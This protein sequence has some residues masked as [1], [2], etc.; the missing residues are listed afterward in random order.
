LLFSLVGLARR[1]LMIAVPAGLASI[2]AAV[3]AIRIIT[4]RADLDRV[5]GSDWPWKIPPPRRARMLPRRWNWRTP[6]A[7]EPR[8][9]R[10]VPFATISGTDR[11]LLC[12]IWQ[13]PEG[14]APSGLAFIYLFGSA[15]YILDKD[16][17]TR[18]LFRH[19]AAQGHVIM[20]V[21]YRLYPETDIPGMVGDASGLLSG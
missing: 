4:P 12:D 5:F 3:A 8:W 7:P 1:S 10:D 16:V 2:G 20:D 9:Q 13:P 17:G 11:T 6:R 14:V 19:L 18:P 21:A 15:S